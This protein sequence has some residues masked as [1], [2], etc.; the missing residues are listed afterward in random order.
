MRV[1]FAGLGVMG[2]PIALNLARAGYDLV[3]WS[4]SKNHYQE[5]ENAGAKVSTS[6]DDLAQRCEVIVLMLADSSAMDQVLNRGTEIFSNLVRGK[7]I[8]NMGTTS[9]EYSTGLSADIQNSLGRY[10]EAPVSGSR[11]PA[12][13][14]QLVGML[15]GEASAVDTV[16]EILEPVCRQV[17]ECGPVPRALHM[18]LA[19]NLF[20]I[21]MVAGLAESAH[22]AQQQG[23]DLNLFRSI[24]DVGPMASSVSKIK[25]GK[26]VDGD[27]SVQASISDVLKNNQLVAQAARN[28]NIASPMLDTSHALFQETVNLG[29]AREDMAA[30]IKAI[31]ARSKSTE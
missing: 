11:Q 16:R 4:R 24:L 22:F 15:A 26:L 21:T 12:I 18:K 9:P 2:V 13:D 14:G 23:L 20:L 5:L 8:V 30:V 17:Y 19:V 29:F 25:L 1:G 10:V 6:F 3:V 7:I 31:E 28:A 27:F